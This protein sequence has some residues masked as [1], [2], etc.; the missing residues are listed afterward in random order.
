MIR[1]E[2][3]YA[4]SGGV[5]VACQVVG[6]GLI[7]IV[8]VQGFISNLE[9]QWEDTGLAHLFNRLGSFARLIV[10]D[11]RGSG[12]SDRASDM[13]DRSDSVPWLSCPT[14][15]PANHAASV[16]R[17]TIRHAR[18]RVSSR[19]EGTTAPGRSRDGLAPAV[20]A[21]TAAS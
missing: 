11:K 16:S 9:V 2:T 15:S 5:H 18:W 19:S 12:P 4:R 1:P 17:D 6:D 20:G 14:D 3:K 7:D 21:T 13:P 8:F 10:F